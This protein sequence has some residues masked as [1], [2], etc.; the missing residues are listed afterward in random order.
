MNGIKKTVFLISLVLPAFCLSH[1]E[2]INLEQARL[3]ALASSRSLAKYEL[4]LRSSILDERNQLYSM[5]PSVSAGYSA[6]STFMKDFEFVN[7]LDTLSAGADLSITQI[8]FQGGKSFIN[9][10]LSLIA[11]E[12]V[13]KS[14]LAEYFSVL[15]SVDSAYYA[16]LEAAAAL[17]AE[18]AAL[19]NAV[20]NLSVTEVRA[21]NGIA[22]QGDYLKALADKETRENSRNQARRT[23]SLNMTKLRNLTGAAGDVELEQVDFGAYE[24]VLLRLSAVSD[25][26]ADALYEELWKI[27]ASSNPSLSQSALSSQRAEKN[28]SLA[29]AD[30]SPVVSATLFAGG[31]NY[32]PSRGLSVTSSGSVT[33]KGSIPLDFWVV[34]NRLE[35]SKIAAQSAALD[36]ANAQTSLETE[37][38]SALLNALAQAGNVLSSRKSLEYIERNYEIVSQRYRLSQGSASEMGEASSLLINSRNSSIKAAYGFLQSLSKL[39]SLCALDDEEKLLAVLLGSRYLP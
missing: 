31:V 5:L 36:Y 17:E 33:I 27:L 35:K 13:R 32:T 39:R 4:S 1:A 12:S 8:I 30:L 22:N 34:A 15:D 28:L 38:Q 26:E 23:L 20:L 11:A 6:S 29:R 25:E 19:A 14:A 2:K 18:E 3:L 9:R 16:V 7:P 10:A 24:E 21:Q 37:L